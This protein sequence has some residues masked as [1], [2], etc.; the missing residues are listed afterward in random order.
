MSCASTRSPAGSPRRSSR[1]GSA[2]RTE[3][4]RAGDL[5][6]LRADLPVSSGSVK[7][8]LIKRKGQLRR[9]L[10]QEAG[11]A[12]GISALS[13]AVWLL[14]GGRHRRRSGRRG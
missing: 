10:A 11:G 13:V 3:P 6:V 5:D 7:L 4:R 1:T 2:A 9:R 8:A 12:I 14:T